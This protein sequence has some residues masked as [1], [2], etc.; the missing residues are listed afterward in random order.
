MRKLEEVIGS[1]DMS[2]NLDHLADQLPTMSDG[3]R[4]KVLAEEHAKA[5]IEQ[6]PDADERVRAKALQNA[7]LGIQHDLAHTSLKD[8]L[9]R[10]LEDNGHKLKTNT[11]TQIKKSVSRFLSTIDKVDIPL[12]DIRRKTVK[13]FINVQL[14]HRAGATVKNYVTFMSSIWKHAADIEDVSGSNPFAG[15]KIEKNVTQS[16]QLFSDIELSAIFKTTEK[17]KDHKENFKYIIPRLGYVTGCRIEELC[18]LTCEQIIEDIESRIAYIQVTDGKTANAVRKIPIHEW[19]KDAVLA[20]KKAVGTGILFPLLETQRNDGKRGDK[21]SK[22]FGR[23]KSDFVTRDVKTGFHS[24]RVHVATN[25]EQA[26]VAE[27]TAVWIL[28]HT[29]NLSLSYGLYS[30]GPTLG[31]LKEVIELID[32]ADDWG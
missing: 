27:S 16:F 6:I 13:N 5:Y 14:A 17:Y 18:S 21:V 29:R 2:P 24:F 1:K 4:S 11:H 31:Q 30:K 32:V 10:H 22:W 20:Q 7:Y 26:E 15:H 19:V 8:A 25:F 9:T 12:K 23:L 28:G 3:E